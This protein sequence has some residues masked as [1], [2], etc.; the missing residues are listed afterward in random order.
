MRFFLVIVTLC[1]LLGA[2]ITVTQAWQLTQ[3]KS[4]ALKA[5]SVEKE[6]A[7]NMRDG[8][9]SMYLPQIT[10]SGSYTRLD[11]PVELDTSDVSNFLGSLPIPI[12]FPSSVDLTQE[13]VFLAHIDMLWPLYTGGKIDA[14]QDIY[15]SR[16][17]EASAKAMMQ[18]DKAF[19]NFIKV[20]YG[21]II[22]NSLY[23]TRLE[24]QKAL[25]LHFKHAQKLKEQGQIA[26]VELL[27]VKVKLDEA[28]I[29]STKARHKL[30]IAQS[31]LN[32]MLH[33]KEIPSSPLFVD[34]ATD[35]QQ[36]YTD[37]T[38]QNYPALSILDHKSDQVGSS[39]TIQKAAYHPTVFA[40]GDYMLYKDDSIA[41]EMVPRWFAGLGIK[42][43]IL[44]RDGRSEKIEAA[45][46]LK[47][48]LDL[49]RADAIEKLSLLVEKTYNEMIL[50]QD[51]YRALTS[52]LV[53]AKEN[54]KLRQ[55]AFREG[56][57]TSLELVDA[58]LFLMASKTKRL[59][60]AYHYVQ[61]IAQLAVLSGDRDRFFNI[62]Q[63][64]AEVR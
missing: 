64:A 27:S 43:D 53:L 47:R 8:A 14:A 60:A 38:L 16:L 49:K 17:D 59:N 12:E 15:Q 56:I 28:K 44:S 41:M 22:A 10:L 33:K 35:T 36:Y 48:E 34:G 31:A 4:S 23:E 52:S 21:V 51:E 58:Q 6:R 1:T 5:L 7:K 54:V 20:Y 32:K 13:D 3:D 19:I 39:I 37:E 61:S 9:G 29:E 11:K 62:A 45:K 24:A 55:I 50:Y 2:D 18:T 57:S 46:L 63:E 42:F 40:F 25:Q 26:K 30:D